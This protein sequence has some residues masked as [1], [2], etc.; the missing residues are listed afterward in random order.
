MGKF[1]TSFVFKVG[2]LAS[3]LMLSACADRKNVSPFP[4]ISENAQTSLSAPVNCA[5][6]PQDIKTLEE[7]RASVGK[8]ILSGVR[9]ILPIAAVAGIL[10]GDYRDRVEVASGK[11]ND[12]INNKI[13]EIKSTCGIH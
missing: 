7:E 2:V 12:D 9:S 6:A 8:R 4:T 1:T 10:M 3:C 5:T 11:Y 13:A